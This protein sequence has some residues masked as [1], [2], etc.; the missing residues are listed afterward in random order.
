MVLFAVQAQGQCD[1]TIYEIQ[2]GAVAVGTLV[3]PCDLVVT[4]TN[5]NGFWCAEAPYGAYNGI[6]VYTGS[7][8]PHGLVEGDVVAVCGEYKE[9]YDL[10]EIDVVSAGIYGSTLKTGTTEVPLPTVL[11]AE[12]LMA[13][14]EPWESCVITI[15]DGME[16]TDITL[17][18]GEWLSMTLD[19]VELRFD[20]VFYDFSTIFEGQCHNNAT[21][22]WTYTF[23]NYKLLPFVDGLEVV[24]C[25]VADESMSMG[26]VKALYR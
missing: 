3:N 11:A 26:S 12:N 10:S 24:E 17:G 18:Y 13:D 14:P 21:G 9:Y 6:W 15:E 16:V 1:V 2:T 8:E 25:G 5:Y 23:S 19:M 7:T 22:I 20:D 4:A